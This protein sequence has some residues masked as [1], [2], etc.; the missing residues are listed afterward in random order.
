MSIFRLHI[1][2]LENNT[3]PQNR[4]PIWGAIC[5]E[6]YGYYFPDENWYDAVSSI[7]DM[8]LPAI[9]EFMRSKDS[10]CELYFMD[11]PYRMCLD[12]ASTNEVNISMLTCDKEVAAARCCVQDFLE[13]ILEGADL[14]CKFCRDNNL[15]FTSSRTFLRIEKNS[16]KM[17]TAASNLK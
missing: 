16:K 4:L 9:I 11:G 8:W 2:S 3:I 14:F 6:A 15:C 13:A 1:K 17:K 5:I 10:L 12:W 7:L